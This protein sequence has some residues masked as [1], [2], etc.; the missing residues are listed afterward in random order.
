MATVDTQVQGV[1]AGGDGSPAQTDSTGQQQS[2]SSVGQNRPKDDNN[3]GHDE[4]DASSE[5][6]DSQAFGKVSTFAKHTVCDECNFCVVL[7][8]GHIPAQ[9]STKLL[10]R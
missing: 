5:N 10:T 2:T 3:D 7:H 4:M 6:S 9:K 1:A 8:N